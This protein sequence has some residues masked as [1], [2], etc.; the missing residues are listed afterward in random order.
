MTYA[1]LKTRALSLAKELGR[2]PIATDAAE[3]AGFCLEGFKAF[4]AYVWPSCGEATA[5]INGTNKIVMETA[6]IVAVDTVQVAGVEL[7]DR[8]GRPGP[9]PI[10]YLPP[11]PGSGVPTEWATSAPGLVVFDKSPTSATTIKMTGH[12]AAQT[13]SDATVLELQ[14]EWL[15]ILAKWMALWITQGVRTGSA[16][17]VGDRMDA[18]LVGEIARLSKGDMRSPFLRMRGEAK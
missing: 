8:A 9:V 13:V 7:L 11:T 14:V 18:A 10:T 12:L 15:N 2:G 17:D 16:Q 6:G 5:S 4:Y 3:Y 1:E